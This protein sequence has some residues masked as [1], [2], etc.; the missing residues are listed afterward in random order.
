MIGKVY[1][2]PPQPP[3]PENTRYLSAGALTIGV[4]YREVDPDNLVATYEGN[5]AYLDELVATSPAGGF[6]D[7]GVS[8]HVCAAE[9]GYE[10]VRFDVFDAEPHY[11]YIHRGDEVCN[12]VIE[13]DTNANGDMLPWVVDRLRTRLPEMLTEAGAAHLV[14]ELDAEVIGRTVDEVAT[15]AQRAQEAQRALRR[16]ART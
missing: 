1:T 9:D 4:E 5:Q 15:M 3:I 11:H 12:N 13:F 16:A 10:Y 8:I 6:T 2:I 14:P 7:E